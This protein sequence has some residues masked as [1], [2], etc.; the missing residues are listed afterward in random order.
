M[1]HSVLWSE[2]WWVEVVSEWKVCWRRCV[3]RLNGYFN[4][5]NKWNN[6]WWLFW[7]SGLFLITMKSDTSHV[8]YNAVITNIVVANRAIYTLSLHFHKTAVITSLHTTHLL[9][10]KQIQQSQIRE[11][12]ITTQMH[13]IVTLTPHNTITEFLCYFYYIF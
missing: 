4:K 11:N 1:R 3:V 5:Q 2:V 8:Y 6:W 13:I 9:S 12:I 10:R 7:I